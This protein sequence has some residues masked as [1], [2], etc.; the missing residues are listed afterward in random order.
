MNKTTA[1]KRG[2]TVFLNKQQIAKNKNKNPGVNVRR[3]LG[4]HHM[5]NSK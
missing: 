3:K 4:A 2:A 5:V 1:I